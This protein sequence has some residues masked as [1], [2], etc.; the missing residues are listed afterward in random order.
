M[1]QKNKNYLINNKF[2]DPICQ[3]CNWKVYESVQHFLLNCPKYN[4]QR[5]DLKN[6]LKKEIKKFDIQNLLFPYSLNIS[7]ENCIKIYTNIAEYVRK[8]ERFPKPTV[9]LK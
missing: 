4:T 9:K 6:N 2:P 7:L 8:S 1:H 3:Q 5:N